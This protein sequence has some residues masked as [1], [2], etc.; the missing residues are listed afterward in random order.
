M[1]TTVALV[2]ARPETINEDYRRV[3][4]LSGLSNL[5]AGE[6]PQLLVGVGNSGFVPGWNATPWQVHGVLDWLGQQAEGATVAGVT[7]RGAG[8][9]PLG[10][11]WQDTLTRYQARPAEPEFL[12]THRHVSRQLHPALDA[13]LPAGVQV[14]VGLAEGPALILASPTTRAG[15]ELAGAAEIL[16]DL[17]ICGASAR[18]KAPAVE[19]TAEAV[20]VARELMPRLGAVLDGTL[21]GVGRGA[22]DRSCV[23]RNILL[24]GT[25]PVAVDA[26][27][28]RLAG[29][30]PQR[31]PWLRLCRDRGF[32]QV[33][34]AEIQI[35]GRTD[36]LDL[37]FGVSG[38]ELG[39]RTSGGGQILAGP[40]SRFIDRVLGRKTATGLADT[41][42]SRLY[43]E[44]TSGE[45][46]GLTGAK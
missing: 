35:V 1:R 30:E 39:S 5:L 36:L 4:D 26:V 17:V 45:R 33:M 23:A 3:L 21:W 13:V 16:Q 22:G 15:W 37:D 34:P 40:V 11:M 44:Y 10:A 32:G 20:G 24:A 43:E 8:L 29:V 19:V 28:L 41:V 6:V 12:R 18:R 27:A 2:E 38:L 9:L 7:K 14:P 31:V 46:A 42:W 25:D